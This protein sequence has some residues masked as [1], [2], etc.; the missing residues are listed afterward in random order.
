M[1]LVLARWNA[2][3][4]AAAAREVLP[5]CGSKV[6]AAR[7]SKMRPFAEEAEL[8]QAAVEVWAALPAEDWQEAFDSHPRIGQ[9]HAQ[10][11][12]TAESLR[13]SGEE[14]RAVMSP[15]DVAKQALAEG[16][17]RYEERFDRIFIVCA[18]GRSAAEI[19]AILEER[20]SNEDAAELQEAAEQQRQIT[21]LRL[22]RWLRGE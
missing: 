14:Q 7:L 2:R 18:A 12:A 9:G 10:R 11:E 17:R 5:C 13:W 15:D 21:Q 3:D 8:K 4:E 16:N 20:L 6:W 22:Q 1:N 19:L